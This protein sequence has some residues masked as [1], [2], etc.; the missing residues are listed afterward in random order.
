MK[1]GLILTLAVLCLVS[2][3]IFTAAASTGVD[4]II[5]SSGLVDYGGGGYKND[6]TPA[7]VR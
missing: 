1:K 3:M 7:D 5:A 2:V 4:F 6:T